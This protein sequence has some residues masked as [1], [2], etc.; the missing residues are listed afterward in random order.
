MLLAQQPPAKATNSQVSPTAI[1]YFQ[2]PPQDPQSPHLNDFALAVLATF[3][4]YR[5]KPLSSK[6][7]VKLSPPCFKV[8]FGFRC[9]SGFLIEQRFSAL[10]PQ[11][12][13]ER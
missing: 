7:M 1:L 11:V 3:A 2:K 6:F 9:L 5:L 12:E 4:V 10:T 8:N 13:F